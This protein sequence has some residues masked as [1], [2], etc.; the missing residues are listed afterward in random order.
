[1]RQ[2]CKL[3]A[4]MEASTFERLV[5]V[6][7]ILKSGTSPN[8]FSADGEDVTFVPSGSHLECFH[9]ASQPPTRIRASRTRF[10]FP[11]LV[12]SARG[13]ASA[14]GDAVHAARVADAPR[15]RDLLLR[16]V[17]RQEWDRCTLPPG[18][19]SPSDLNLDAIDVPDLLA[20]LA[21]PCAAPDLRGAGARA[22]S[23]GAPASA[24]PPIVASEAGAST[25]P[26]VTL[27]SLL[28]V[29]TT[30]HASVRATAITPTRINPGPDNASARS[31]SLV[32][33]APGQPPT[34]AAVADVAGVGAPVP[35]LILPLIR[36]GAAL[37]SDDAI[38][39]CA[40]EIFTAYLA[41]RG[42]T[43]KADS[44]SA[45]AT[46][47]ALA[48][49]ARYSLEISPAAAAASAALIA[50]HAPKMRAANESSAFGVRLH[51]RLAAEAAGCGVSSDAACTAF[52]A[53]PTARLATT[54]R[55]IA[56]L[57][58]A[59]WAV[60]DRESSAEAERARGEPEEAAFPEVDE[61]HEHVGVP[62]VGAVIEET[63]R[64]VSIL[65]DDLIV[66]EG[67][68][69]ALASTTEAVVEMVEG[70]LDAAGER[71]WRYPLALAGRAHAALL[72]GAFDPLDEGA[73]A[74][75]ADAYLEAAAGAAGAVGV[76]LAAHRAILAWC[77][78]TRYRSAALGEDDFFAAALSS[79]TSTNDAADAEV[80]GGSSRVRS[81]AAQRAAA[82][83]GARAFSRALE[84]ER[85][86]ENEADAHA[87]L[88]A[89][90]DHLADVTSH[91]EDKEDDVDARSDSLAL[92]HAALGP[93]TWWAEGCLGDFFA[94]ASPPA[95]SL[96]R[97]FDTLFVMDPTRRRVAPPPSLTPAAFTATLALAA[98]AA[99]A[100]ATIGAPTGTGAAA[101]K[102]SASAAAGALAARACKHSAGEAYARLSRAAV[103]LKVS[104]GVCGDHGTFSALEK[105]SADAVARV[106][107]GCAALADAF[108]A[109]LA[110]AVVR[111]GGAA[112]ANAC[113]AA[114]AEY[115][116][117]DLTAW[118]DGIPPLDA[119][120]IRAVRASMDFQAAVAAAVA[121][122]DGG[123]VLP[124]H[125]E[126]MTNDSAAADIACVGAGYEPLRLGSLVAPLVF[127]WV[128]D[129]LDVLRATSRRLLEIETWG[130]NGMRAIRGA[131]GDVASTSAVEL[132]RA[133]W[134]TLEAFWALRGL[135]TPVAALRALTEGL[136][137]V[138]Q[139]YAEA[140]ASAL[141]RPEAF[142]PDLPRLTR[143]K[144]DVVEKARTAHEASERATRD[145]DRTDRTGT[146]GTIRSPGLSPGFSSGLMSAP[147]GSG[148]ERIETAR[149]EG[150]STTLA[151]LCSR[152]ASIRF[153]RRELDEIEREVPARYADMMRD[154]VESFEAGSPDAAL[155]RR[156]ET[157]V[158][159][160]GRE[161]TSAAWLEG[162]LDGARQ[163]LESCS[164]KVADH[165]ACKIAYRHLRGT[166]V[167]GLYR[168]GVDSG[169]SADAVTRG[170]FIAARL[171]AALCAVAD[172]LPPSDGSDV[173]GVA[174]NSAAA[175]P[176][177]EARDAIAS[178]LARATSQAWMR[179]MLDGGPTR[180]F[181]EG[182][183]E[184]LEED[185]N[186]IRET[187]LAGGDGV[188]SHEVAAVFRAPDRLL[189]VMSL[190]TDT[191][192]GMYSEAQV[193]EEAA[194]VKPDAAL[195]PGGG[196][197]V[198]EWD[199][200]I[201]GF[202]AST[203]LR[204]LCHR[205]D[206]AASKFL[207]T[208]ARL[209]KG[210]EGAMMT[211]ANA[212]YATASKGYA[213]ASTFFGGGGANASG[214]K[215]K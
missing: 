185:L 187:F 163:T 186:E 116:T 175:C 203:L 119:D 129:R 33:P 18:V 48:E 47:A 41:T 6:S 125:A 49:T 111:H 88:Y 177:R 135:P 103:V 9:P 196:G 68:L 109:H 90:A 124:A 45:A 53:S 82:S 117:A 210:D 166:F 212:G 55:H 39:A 87:L 121:G 188:P 199:E 20:V 86:A 91:E 191:L 215:G 122:R 149:D 10:F 98:A 76:D 16:H 130:V 24:P 107:E 52:G 137:G 169:S 29:D 102:D 118:L 72:R 112:A 92:A 145:W 142:A 51:L 184:A 63:N 2:P 61:P 21:R 143:Y 147:W 99:G 151:A 75:D 110:P 101:L 205:R 156:G 162:L 1:M 209:P 5:P 206:R 37:A 25:P 40:Y 35:D 114:I 189:V 60:H 69:E 168:H 208:A 67:G 79:E 65:S 127:R 153:V 44:P 19:A 70:A 154:A 26:V 42:T 3:S 85:D 27:S 204:V 190:D 50:P 100:R 115:F 106:A 62:H 138:A 59:L 179:V 97:C 80:G 167:D 54:R 8:Y 43:L 211:L 155:L 71:A 144:A 46:N 159:L 94:D 194:G 200:S 95:S 193:R 181:A 4:A 183:L 150:T 22:E 73:L 139:Y 195:A 105:T 7:R 83:A 14:D 38:A 11:R 160:A 165:I 132:V 173:G 182:D 58:E 128:A 108:E 89:A 171:E 202:G 66:A 180:V 198:G 126:E 15:D 30:A 213:H 36:G 152:L 178:A 192:C 214:K 57:V 120:G 12:V 31:L 93:V 74:E 176:S 77:L 123:R 78:A 207:K 32:R 81:P 141:G 174:P 28:H 170:G 201:G 17:L 133:M 146:G 148:P 197:S 13:M 140:V 104:T 56:V 134:D 172:A 161:S 157:H 164:G 34:P 131:V 158:A 23:I 113:P 136:D 64:L 84:A 96:A